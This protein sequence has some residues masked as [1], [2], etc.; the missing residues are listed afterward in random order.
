M[1]NYAAATLTTSNRKLPLLQQF[2]RNACQITRYKVGILH[3]RNLKQS[4]TRIKTFQELLKA[5]TQRSTQLC[6]DGVVVDSGNVQVST[7]IGA[8]LK[9]ENVIEALRQREEQLHQ[10]AE[11][12]DLNQQERE[13]GAVQGQ[14]KQ[15]AAHIR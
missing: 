12:R 9:S 2:V 6:S 7:T 1:N 10:Q 4:E 3:Y 5:F 13:E 15:Q 11:E 14:F 8:T